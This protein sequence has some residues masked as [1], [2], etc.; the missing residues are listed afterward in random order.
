[1]GYGY[2]LVAALSLQWFTQKRR[3]PSFSNSDRITAAHTVLGLFDKD[4]REHYIDLGLL[5]TSSPSACS[6]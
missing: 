6:L 4:F 5:E 3:V 2:R 1:M